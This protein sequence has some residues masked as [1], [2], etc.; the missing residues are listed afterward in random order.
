LPSFNSASRFLAV[1]IHVGF[2][3]YTRAVLLKREGIFLQTALGV[4]LGFP[5]AGD[6]R[7]QRGKGSDREREECEVSFH[8]H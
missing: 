7:R 4:E 2:A 1:A 6:I 5:R 3:R 8:V